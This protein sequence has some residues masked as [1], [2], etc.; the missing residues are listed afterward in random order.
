[1]KQIERFNLI[2]RIGRELQ[3]RMTFDDIDIYLSGFGVESSDGERSYNSKWVY[4]K[5]RLRNASDELV[6]QIADEL[7][8]PHPHVVLPGS[9]V[10]ESRFWE[11][12]S[13]R[14]FLSH[15]SSFKGKTAALQ[16]SLR[17]YGISSFVAHLDIE[18]TRKWQEEIERALFSMDALVAILMPGFKESNW[19]DQ[20]VGVAI[21]RGIPVIPIMKGL[22]PYGFHRQ[23]PGI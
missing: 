8:L 15:L 13:F 5:D 16:Q 21:G 22:N 10:G 4:A 23:V 1:M 7:E 20:E 11:A 17:P 2:D 9:A 6:V 18:P 19:T 12:G 3:S 14:L